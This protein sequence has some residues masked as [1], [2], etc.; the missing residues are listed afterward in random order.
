MNRLW[1][2]LLTFVTVLAVFLFTNSIW[3]MIGAGV[4]SVLLTEMLTKP[5]SKFNKSQKKE[6]VKEDE[7][8][9]RW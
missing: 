1:G 6:S 2:Y 5:S 4:V 9:D 7:K 8:E 3:W